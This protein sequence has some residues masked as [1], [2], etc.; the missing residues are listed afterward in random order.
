MCGPTLDMYLI[1]AKATE[2]PLDNS[3]PNIALFIN[4]EMVS[5]F[6]RTCLIIWVNQTEDDKLLILIDPVYGMFS[7]KLY[8]FSAL[9][10]TEPATV[11]GT[12]MLYL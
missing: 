6:F 9:P 11:L 8:S 10:T 5:D 12:V 1:R 7:M 2:P 4:A 3:H